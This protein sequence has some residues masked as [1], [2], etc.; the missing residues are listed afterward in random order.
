MKF[1]LFSTA[2]FV[3]VVLFLTSSHEISYSLNFV[4]HLNKFKMGSKYLTSIY[5]FTFLI[6]K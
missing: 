6:D 1:S 3:S 5:E 2:F 4:G